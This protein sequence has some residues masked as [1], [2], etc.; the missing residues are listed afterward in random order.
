M[1][2]KD[3]IFVKLQIEKDYQSGGLTLGIYFDKNA[4]NFTIEKDGMNWSPTPEELEFIVETFD[5]VSNRKDH[6]KTHSTINKNIE[7]N[8]HTNKETFEPPVIKTEL[9]KVEDEPLTPHT[10]ILEDS[11]TSEKNEEQIFIQANDTTI[12]E[13]LKRKK[14]EQTDIFTGEVDEKIIIDKVLK[15]KIKN[16]K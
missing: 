6:D 8:Y 1:E 14:A 16:K 4:P 9:N 11:N 15:D 5:L 13:A 10:E 12:E 7:T 2:K 3:N